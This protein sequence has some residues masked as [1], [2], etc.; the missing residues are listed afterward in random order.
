MAA[1][2]HHTWAR[3]YAGR[4]A[5]PMKAVCNSK[6]KGCHYMIQPEKIVVMVSALKWSMPLNFSGCY[7]RNR[8]ERMEMLHWLAGDTQSYKTYLK[9]SSH[10]PVAHQDP[11]S[12]KLEHYHVPMPLIC[13]VVP[14][15]WASKIQ[16]VLLD[17]LCKCDSSGI[18]MCDSV[19]PS[20]RMWERE[21]NR[22][23]RTNVLRKNDSS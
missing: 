17:G 9:V 15:D 13:S 18:N 6:M 21:L 10:S 23:A 22:V 20:M 14:L 4:S 11:M 8:G 12:K 3:S 7:R 5:R 1:W 2:R 19:R 16:D